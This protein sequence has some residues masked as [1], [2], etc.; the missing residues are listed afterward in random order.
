MRNLEDIAWI[1][2]AAIF[3][4]RAAFGRLVE[5]YQAQVRR[6]FLSQTLGDTQLSDD[7]AQDT[8]VKAYLNISRF[9]GEASFSTWLFRIAYNVYYDH[10]KTQHP[11]DS[12]ET[13]AVM[14]RSGR[15]TDS[16]LQMDL[17]H[18]LALLT[19]AERTCVVLQ[20]MEG[21]S[22]DHITMVTGMREGT[23]KSHLSHGKKK[24]ADYL[25][26]NGYD[27]Q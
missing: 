19:D 8:F 12:L 26:H 18:A 5:K 23:V 14:G 13:P 10:V 22:I 16:G 1:T 6:F 4:N 7:L 25:R 21:Q 27:R 15:D 20:L 3:H 24:M 2:Q 9:R 17:R 11:T